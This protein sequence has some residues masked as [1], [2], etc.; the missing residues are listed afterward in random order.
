VTISGKS[1]LLLSS[2]AN[3]A[4][5]L[6]LVLFILTASSCQQKSDDDVL[7]GTTE[8]S[9]AAAMYSG[10]EIAGKLIGQLVRDP[11]GAQ[12]AVEINHEMLRE[13]VAVMNTD[14]T[15]E[16]FRDPLLAAKLFAPHIGVPENV[17]F[18]ITERS[19]QVEEASGLFIAVV[20]V[21]N[22]GETVIMRMISE[23]DSF[24]RPTLWVLNDFYH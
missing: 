18:S 11:G 15:L 14:D 1:G 21:N 22:A 12:V 24:D 20:T 3:P 19:Q 17:D 23:P 7:P 6:I 13:L 16:S 2:G 9:P 8:D 5:W 10:H 4:H